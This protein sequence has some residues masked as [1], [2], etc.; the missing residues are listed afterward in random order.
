MQKEFL[1]VMLTGYLYKD[2][3]YDAITKCFSIEASKKETKY[4][5]TLNLVLRQKQ[6]KVPMYISDILEFINDKYIYGPLCINQRDNCYYKFN[7]DIYVNFTINIE[8]VSLY[9]DYEEGFKFEEYNPIDRILSRNITGYF[10]KGFFYKPKHREILSICIHPKN[11]F[12]PKDPYGEQNYIAIADVDKINPPKDPYGEQNYIAIADVDKI[13][14][15]YY[16]DCPIEIIDCIKSILTNEPDAFKGYLKGN[17][18]KYI[19]RENKKG[20]IE[21]LKKAKWYL[22]KLINEKEIQ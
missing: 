21:D 1:D 18:I 20:G 3:K 7:V 22:N 6:K 2:E 13:N 19:S 10:A 12:L 14:P 4:T 17:I 15:G 8:N 5:Y 9:R 11:V 16:K